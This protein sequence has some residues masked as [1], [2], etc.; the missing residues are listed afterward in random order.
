[1]TLDHIVI[2]PVVTEKTNVMR[3][4]HK[5]VFRVDG[6]ANKLQI[7]KAVRDQFGVHPVACNIIN[8]T[9][10]PKKVRYREGYTASW[11]KAIITL[12]AEEKI[13]IFEGV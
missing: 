1:M 4:N 10:K 2:A 3:E 6:R 5:Y 11:K 8:I 9:P 7:M 12:P 13:A